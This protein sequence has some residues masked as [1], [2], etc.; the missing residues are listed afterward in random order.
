MIMLAMFTLNVFH[1][2]VL[3]RES[4]YPYPTSSN[5][6]PLVGQKLSN[7]SEMKAV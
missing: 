2:G 7:Y 5:V 6:T 4:V 3:M 1:P